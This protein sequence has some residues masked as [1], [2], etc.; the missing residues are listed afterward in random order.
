MLFWKFSTLVIPSSDQ[1][2]DGNRSCGLYR[3]QC[4]NTGLTDWTRQWIKCQLMSFNCSKLFVSITCRGIMILTLFV[5]EWLA[6][7][8]FRRYG[9]WEEENILRALGNHARF[10]KGDA[11]FAAVRIEYHRK[12][13]MYKKKEL[14]RRSTPASGSTVFI[15]RNRAPLG[16]SPWT[17]RGVPN[18]RRYVCKSVRRREIW[19]AN[20][21]ANACFTRRVLLSWTFTVLLYYVLHLYE[22]TQWQK[23]ETDRPNSQNWTRLG[24]HNFLGGKLFHIL[25]SLNISKTRKQAAVIQRGDQ[26]MLIHANW[27]LIR[28]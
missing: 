26:S 10:A 17:F 6:W 11:W 1:I 16:R 13:A 22:R 21:T 4:T 28:V 27:H 7:K 23:H 14:L 12:L 5:E 8:R 25:F 19:R 3:L 20:T 15:S 2:S 18:L 24:G 9:T